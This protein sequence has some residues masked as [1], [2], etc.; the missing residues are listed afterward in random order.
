MA[1][2]SLDCILGHINGTKV[3]IVVTV[4]NI[5]L[6]LLQQTLLVAAKASFDTMA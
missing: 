4:T 1:S 2:V 5:H 3:S 6:D